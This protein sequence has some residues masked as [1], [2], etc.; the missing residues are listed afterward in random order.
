M[1]YELELFLF[2][3]PHTRQKTCIEE[4]AQ[5][6]RCS[7]RYAKKIIQKLKQQNI[8]KWETSR[9]RGKKPFLT[10]LTTKNDCISEIFKSYWLKEKFDEAYTLLGEHQML[11][12]P[13]IQ[14]WLQ[15]QYGIQH[16]PNT[17]IVFRYPLYHANLT[18]NPLLADTNYDAHFIKQLHETLFKEN[19]MTGEVEGNLV[20]HYETNDHINWRLILRKGVFFHDLKPVLASDVKDSLERIKSIAKPYFAIEKIGIIHNYELLL[21]LSKPFAVLPELLTSFRT[22]ILPKDKP[23]GMIGCGPFMIKEHSKYRV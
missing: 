20:F 11:N 19:E 13:T 23:D 18:L 3:S 12:D 4:L 1:H 15:Q 5:I 17:D 10:L 9:G 8:I 14:L 22:V 2:F 7:N 21:T 6:W 16:K